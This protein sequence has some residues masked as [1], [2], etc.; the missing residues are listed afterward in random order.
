MELGRASL[1]SST[2]FDRGFRF[3]RGRE[4]PINIVEH[5]KHF[6]IKN[7]MMAQLV[8]HYVVVPHHVAGAVC[9]LCLGY[10]LNFSF[11]E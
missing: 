9:R 7:L 11:L 4:R 8:D 3:S 10:N 5:F 2:G 1:L 6:F